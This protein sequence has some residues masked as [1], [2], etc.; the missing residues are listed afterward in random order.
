[1][2]I[3]ILKLKFKMS[4]II[5]VSSQNFQIFSDN[6][7]ELRKN[8]L[9]SQKYLNLTCIKLSDNSIL[10]ICDDNCFKCYNLFD[11]K[12]I[13][14][15]KFGN[16]I[17]KILW[18]RSLHSVVSLKNQNI[19]IIG[20][21]SDGYPHNDIISL[22]FETNKFKSIKMKNGLMAMSAVVLLDGRVLI[23]GGVDHSNNS[24]KLCEIF[25]PV[26]LSFTTIES[27]HYRR[28]FPSSVILPNGNVFVSGGEDKNNFIHDSCEEYDV[29]N[30]KWILIP[31]MLNRRYKHTSVLLHNNNILVMGGH[32]HSKNSDNQILWIPTLT[33]EIFNI[34]TSKWILSENLLHEI[35][36]A[37]AIIL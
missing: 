3:L 19:L 37:S 31:P 16:Y 7:W 30:N 35:T 36:N 1:M 10:F 26:D 22:N 32:T 8:I 34:E 23:I 9:N 21:L 14:I 27:M 15:V 2:K 20:G 28:S 17:N 12:N 6:K 5:L 25:N 18:S 33:C 4:E 24:T 13:M 29:L 11:H